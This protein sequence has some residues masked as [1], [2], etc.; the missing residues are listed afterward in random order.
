MITVKLFKYLISITLIITVYF[1]AITQTSSA[2]TAGTVF[3]ANPVIGLVDGKPVS[4]PHP[5]LPT[6]LP[7]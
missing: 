7:A 3:H 4:Y 1:T 2:V 6:P 5:P